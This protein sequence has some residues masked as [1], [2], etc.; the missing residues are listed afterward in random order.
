MEHAISSSNGESSEAPPRKRS[1]GEAKGG[2]TRVT[3]YTYALRMT[4]ATDVERDY[5]W[6]S[7]RHGMVECLFCPVKKVPV[8]PSSLKQHVHSK[9]HKSCREGKSKEEK[10]GIRR[11]L[12]AR[13]IAT[14]AGE[15]ETVDLFCAWLLSHDIPL[16]KAASQCGRWRRRRRHV[17]VSQDG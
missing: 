4:L 5:N 9:K 14:T 17:M 12:P 13:S 2:A 7:V 10:K 3:R 6:N 8:N 11:F 15:E 1:R 16:S